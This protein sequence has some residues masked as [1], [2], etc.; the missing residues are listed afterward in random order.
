MRAYVFSTEAVIARY[1][2][3]KFQLMVLL[4]YWNHSVA[5]HTTSTHLGMN[6]KTASSSTRHL[7]CFLEEIVLSHMTISHMTNVS[8][9]MLLAF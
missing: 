6:M 7:Y 3:L 4:L 2:L 8:I 1:T 5:K 9:T